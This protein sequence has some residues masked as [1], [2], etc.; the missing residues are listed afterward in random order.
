[1]SHLFY[2]VITFHECSF[3]S[4]LRQELCLLLMTSQHE[5]TSSTDSDWYTGLLILL[6]DTALLQIYRHQRICSPLSANI[7]TVF[8][9]LEKKLG[10]VI[11]SGVI[12]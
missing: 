7:K 5:V 2:T 4:H 10:L 1:M 12:T 11:E 8:L 3:G 9:R 6:A